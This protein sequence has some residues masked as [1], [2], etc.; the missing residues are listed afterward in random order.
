MSAH[1]NFNALWAAAVAEELQRAGVLHAFICPGSRSAPLALALYKQSGLFVHTVLDERSAAFAALGAAKASG[2]PALVLATSGTAGAHF[3]PAVLEAE[4]SGVPLVLLTA[5]RPPELHGFGA[6]QTIDQQHLFGGHV[7]CFADLGAPEP[8][9][10]ALL[11][12]RSVLTV[13][14]SRALAP[15]RGP[16]HLNAPFREPLAPTPGPLPEGLSARARG[17]AGPLLQLAAVETNIQSSLLVSLAAELARRPRGVIV[18]GPRDAED[19]LP[20]ALIELAAA[21]GYALLADAASGVRATS[22]LAI[23]C[24]DLI[25]R[26]EGRAAALRPDA[27][28][29]FGGAPS[30]KVLQGWLDAAQAYT[31]LFTDGPLIDPAHAASI[32]I[33][34]SACAPLATALRARDVEPGGLAQSFAAAQAQVGSALEGAFAKDAALTEPRVARELGAALPPGSQLFV[35]SSMPIRDLDAFGGSLPGVR[36]LASRG[37][38]GIDGIISTALGAA[39]ATERPTA[40]F[41]G[42]VA[43]LHDLGGLIAARRLGAPLVLLVI[44]NDG[45]GI[46][47]FLPVAQQADAESFE[48]LFGTPH[49]IELA[50]AASLAGAELHRPTN[51]AELR[52]AL[53]ESLGRGLHLIEVRTNRRENVARHR[54]LQESAWAALE[55]AS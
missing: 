12:L 51:P 36:V 42:D 55:E 8:T 32:A 39:L 44:N 48:A 37:V 10:A 54:A 1:A 14:L 15:R 16:V 9:E 23:T 34:E 17:A 19:D 30:S 45:G 49:G 2:R 11:H 43:F 26:H 22:S 29:R 21:T 18:C 47:H 40:V 7:R 6:P 41:L 27:V 38:N 31:V 46:F 53:R 28:L 50:A 25:L 13:C 20:K 33:P 5:D 3:Y 24:A 4:A 52:A 35:S